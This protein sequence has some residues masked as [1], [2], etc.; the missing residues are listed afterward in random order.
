MA[1]N[2]KNMDEG[3]FILYLNKHGIYD[4][5]TKKNNG[6]TEVNFA[7]PFEGCDDDRRGKSEE[8]H[9]SFCLED[10]VFHCF[11]CSASGNFIDLL[12]H[13]G[14]YEE[15]DAEQ[16]SKKKSNASVDRRVSFKTMVR[17]AYLK[18][19]EQAYSY[20][21]AR[22]INSSS[23]DENMLGV[24]KNGR[25]SRWMI[26]IFDRDGEVAYLKL[27]RMDDGDEANAKCVAEAM[28]RKPNNPDKY[29]FYPS[30]VTPLLVGE[31]MLIKSSSDSVLV[32]EGEL[33]RIIAIQDGVKMPVVTGSCGAG[34]FKNEWIDALKDMRIIYICYDKDKAGV[35]NAVK[36]AERIAKRIPTASIY[37][38]DLPFESETGAD[39]T[40]YFT[41]NMGTADELFTKYAKYYGGAKPID[42]TQFEELTV[43]DIA[44][45][46]DST[47]KY[48]YVSKVITCLAMVS[49]YT[50]EEQINIMFNASS[51]TGKSY[52][53][54]EVSKYFPQ[55]DVKTYG[56]VTPTAFYYAKSL[57]KKDPETGEP[58]VDLERRILIF[59][60][61]PDSR[62]QEN[63]RSLLAHD[64]KKIPFAN[65]NAGKSG[66]HVT[67][68]GYLLGFPSMFF[69]SANMEVDEQEQTRCIILS[70]EST[71]EKVLASIDA[72]LDR[73]CNKEEYAAKLQGDEAR[74]QFMERILYIKSLKIDYVNISENDNKYL[75]RRFLE[76][77]NNNV[78]PRAS[79]EIHKLTALA[80]AMA[81]IN[82][83]HRM[84]DGK[85]TVARSDIDEALK[86]WRVIAESM[87]NSL[88]PQLFGFYKSVVI[89]A[90]RAKNE[91]RES[92][93]G[94]TL[95]ELR[96]EYYKQYGSYPHMWNMQKEW[97]PMLEASNFIMCE[98]DSKANGGDGRELLITPL[99][100]FD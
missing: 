74:R 6:K 23:V 35:D 52:I 92:P 12:K 65:T 50:Y 98:K 20:F 2:P 34:T 80:K 79:R 43:D 100:F 87:A 15:Y 55:Q 83:T 39:L 69:C 1:S 10:C 57:R 48:D 95:K 21:N 4:T 91:E 16:K 26:P 31:D 86:L 33:D 67:D 90:W 58:Y 62:L 30:G 32:C 49:A 9:C 63:L 68:E 70:P 88:S 51:S 44:N 36:L 97:I 60:E 54:L 71:R 13:F 45:I 17:N 27:R 75:K 28:G 42:P 18:S 22:G 77:L 38:I 94:A 46:L 84:H 24:W 93:K 99:V 89:P 82:V 25:Q 11:K 59:T 78:P 19:R 47:I 41:K 85:V 66:D 37:I 5:E 14:D 96:A 73:S 53:C 64:S 3:E 56:K 76:V 81:L 61:L 7:C 72:Y 29:I 40:D 8:L